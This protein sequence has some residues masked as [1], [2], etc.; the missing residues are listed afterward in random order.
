MSE[1]V[2]LDPTIAWERLREAAADNR[3]PCLAVH[4]DT[5][6][7]YSVN[8]RGHVAT[9]EGML[10]GLLASMATAFIHD[11]ELEIASPTERANAL[12]FYLSRRMHTE[13]QTLTPELI[14][15]KNLH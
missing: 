11:P 5:D 15:A 8:V 1:A 13:E 14:P 3:C 12:M 6:G 7:G 2:E 9:V 10:V 4:L